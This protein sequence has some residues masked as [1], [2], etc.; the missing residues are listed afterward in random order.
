MFTGEG[1]PFPLPCHC[2]AILERAGLDWDEG[3]LR[4]EGFSAGFPHFL[5]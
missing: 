4:A 5:F 2:S 1:S 3:L